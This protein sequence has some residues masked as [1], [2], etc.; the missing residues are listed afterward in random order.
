MTQK[1]YILNIPEIEKIFKEIKEYITFEVV[2]FRKFKD[3]IEQLH[4]DK[5]IFVNSI[6]LIDEKEAKSIAEKIDK[7]KQILQTKSIL[8]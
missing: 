4:N 1:L 2:G 6:I 3:L 5:D 7:N 8:K